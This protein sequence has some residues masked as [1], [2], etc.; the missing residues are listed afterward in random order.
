MKPYF[1][2]EG[3]TYEFEANFMLHKEFN[4]EQQKLLKE[5]SVD[6]KELI[7]EDFINQL[8]LESQKLKKENP[9]ASKEELEAKAYQIIMNDP[10][11]Y[12]TLMTI[13]KDENATNELYEKYCRIMFEKKYPNEK[14]VFDEFLNVLC[15]DKGIIYV[16]AFLES[17]C[18]KVFMN[19]GKEVPQQ[20]T[21]F[22]W[23]ETT[24]V[25]N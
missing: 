17:V 9:N 15:E 16:Y 25:V 11:L 10:R 4:K 3:K 12:K 21:S 23:E 14:E 2:Y 13:E 20:K 1:E 19:V 7:D 6:F 18:K 5:S 8:K 22:A 24:K